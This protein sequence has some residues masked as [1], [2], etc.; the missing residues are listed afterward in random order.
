MSA[1]SKNNPEALT[2]SPCSC[3]YHL[4]VWVCLIFSKQELQGKKPFWEQTK[5]SE[6]LALLFCHLIQQLQKLVCFPSSIFSMYL[7]GALWLFY[8]PAHVFC[9]CWLWRF[10]L[11]NHPAAPVSLQDVVF[12]AE[13]GMH[14]ENVA[15]MIFV[16]ISLSQYTLLSTCF[17]KSFALFCGL[18]SSSAKFLSWGRSYSGIFNQQ[19][20]LVYK[21]SSWAIAPINT[22]A[23]M[24]LWEQAQLHPRILS[25]CILNWL[26][27]NWF[28]S[29]FPD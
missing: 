13:L 18:L 15:R 9:T 25:C 7:E 16:K 4:A 12:K 27:R 8:F 5:N 20:N 28:W 1:K 21:S 10:L 19:A 2:D 29:V 3:P 23:K 24:Q 17:L 11:W 22:V 14:S 26:E 6:T